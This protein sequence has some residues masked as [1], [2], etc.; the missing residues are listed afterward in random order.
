MN[1][2]KGM[3]FVESLVVMPLLLL[4]MLGIIQYTLIY[5]AK[6]SLD[7]ATFMAARNAAIEQGSQQSL[8]HALTSSMLPPFSAG[9]ESQ[10]SVYNKVRSELEQNSKINIVNPTW[11]AFQDHGV[12]VALKNIEIP[13]DRLHV[14]DANI[15]HLSHVN[16]QDAN[17]LKIHVVYGYPLKIPFVNHIIVKFVGLFMKKSQY[18]VYLAEQ[19]LPILSTAIV[20]MQSRM[21]YNSWVMTR[22]EVDGLTKE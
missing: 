13:N 9:G 7:H 15:G 5:V 22:E 11:E 6:T 10:K 4:L 16:V 14:R 21:R 18:K 19:R 8:M 20:R 12:S 2:I 1:Y 3:V 17:L